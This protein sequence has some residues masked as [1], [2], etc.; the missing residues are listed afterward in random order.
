MV[1]FLTVVYLIYIFL[2]LY[3]LSLYLLLYL[4]NKKEFFSSP[5][6]AKIYSID[7]IIP[8]YNEGETIE[9]TINHILESDYPGLKKIIV[10]DDCSTDNSFEIIKKLAKRNNKIIAV[11]TPQNTGKASGSKNYGTKFAKSELIGFIDG[12]S[13]PEKEAIS[14]MVGFFNDEKV[15]AVTSVVL[16]SNRNKLIE[17]FQAIEYR[18]IAFT[19]KL[20]GFVDAIYVT[21]GALA[22]YRKNIFEEIGS[23]DEKNMTED[24]EIT[25]NLVS[26]GYIIRMGSLSKVQTL[27]PQKFRDWMRQRIRWNIGGL[28]TI[29]KYRKTFL[30]KGMLGQFILPFF[31]TSWFVGLSGLFILAYR[32]VQSI[33]VNLLSISY[34]I[35]SQS[36]LLNPNAINLV[37]NIL[38]FFGI[39]LLTLG[40]AFTLIALNH[41]RTEGFKRIGIFSLLGYM[42]IYLLVYPVILII[43]VF[44]ASQGKYSW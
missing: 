21:P 34:S 37:P 13:F 14:G 4:F 10:V 1:Q 19:R 44:R 5:E 31:I 11:Q 18:I 36:T 22:V 16:V 8:C 32:I 30:R 20:L 3:L 12:D 9:K 35:Q 2:S 15:G 17:K 33:A 43:S 42:F 29:K 26:R 39:I 7:M 27:A 40:F 24:I 6:P 25:W 41:T 28:Q 38:F 23:F